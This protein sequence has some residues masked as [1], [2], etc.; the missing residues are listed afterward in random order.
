[1]LCFLLFILQMPSC[2]WAGGEEEVYPF[3]RKAEVGV[4]YLWSMEMKPVA[5][6]DR[7]EKT[8][9]PIAGQ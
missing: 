2:P 1:M 4:V 6:S 5:W 9:V 8:H 7:M 3:I